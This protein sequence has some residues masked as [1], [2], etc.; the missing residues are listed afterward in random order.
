[1]DDGGV[2]HLR[3]HPK[4]REQ[5]TLVIEHQYDG[6]DLDFYELPNALK[7]ISQ[8]LWGGLVQVYTMKQGVTH[9][10]SHNGSKWADEVV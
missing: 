9:I 6:R 5:S 10:A 4:S 2:P 1:M 3:I 7:I 8:R